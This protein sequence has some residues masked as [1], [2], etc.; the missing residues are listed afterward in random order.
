MSMLVA[1][2]V[3]LPVAAAFSGQTLCMQQRCPSTLC[4][5]QRCAVPRLAADHPTV[6]AWPQKYT[7]TPGAAGGPRK[8]HDEFTVIPGDTN[9]LVELDVQNWPTWTTAGNDRWL[10]NDT[11]FDKKMPYGELCY[12]ISGQL[13]IEFDGQVHYINPGDFV[14]LPEGFV[15]DHTVTKTMTWHYFLY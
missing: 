8:L 9:M 7:G 13:K 6:A 5:Q 11:R 14:T 4:M 1:I 2:L 3:V 10:E 15:S 12:M